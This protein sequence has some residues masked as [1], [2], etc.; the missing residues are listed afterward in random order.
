MVLLCIFYA[1]AFERE[2][3]VMAGRMQEL[4]EERD[5]L[6]FEQ[7][8]SQAEADSLKVRDYLKKM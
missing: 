8:E 2:N 1:A 4:S 7:K 3:A 6:A 5:R